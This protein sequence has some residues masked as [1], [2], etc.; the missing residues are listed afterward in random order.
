MK[1]KLLLSAIAVSASIGYATPTVSD[2]SARQRYP[3]NGM[4]DIDYTISGDAS[5]L[6]VQIKVEDR[7]TG[8]T[9]TPSKF[10]SVLPV[11]EGRHRVTWSTEAEGVTI[12]SPDVAIT[13]CL[14]SGNPDVV[15]NNLYYVVDLTEGSSAAHYPVT[16]ITAP[17]GV[18]WSDEFKSN[19]L[20]LRRIESG[21]VPTHEGCRISK[22]FYIGVFEVTQ[23]QWKLVTGSDPSYVNFWKYRNDLNPAC[24]I[25]YDMIRGSGLGSGWPKSS[26]V[27]GT[28]FIGK[29][30]EKTGLMFD[31][32]T[33][34]QWEY[35]C[36]AGETSKYNNGGDGEAD[37]AT[38][39]RY[40]GN[41]ND[42]R[43]GSST[44][45]TVGCYAPNNWG[46]YDMHGNV[47]EWCL[48]FYSFKGSDFDGTDP[49]GAS[50][51]DYSYRVLKGGDYED[52]ALFCTASSQSQIHPNNDVQNHGFRV[53]CP[54]GL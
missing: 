42:G 45:T 41:C 36:R 51:G 22:P 4:V 5:D 27:D 2:V 31:L 43:G 6:S 44:I 37:L 16:T 18:V 39:G 53:V 26:S 34:A 14:V 20:L 38:L 29:L 35:A 47:E 54:A 3:W 28:S 11:T 40:S 8:K 1:A 50:V 12:V 25:S 9:Y 23:K 33:I 32:P 17:D 7:Q 30:R 10:L 21:D 15:K 19:K 24:C 13:V 48:N 46:L 52:G 49:K